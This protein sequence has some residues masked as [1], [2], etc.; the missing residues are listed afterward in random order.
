MPVRVD[1][2]T[3][4]NLLG[5]VLVALAGPLA[6]LALVA[7]VYREPPMPFVIPAVGSLAAGV[8]L[9]RLERSD[10]GPREAFLLVALAWLSVAVVGAIPFVI[11]GV[12]TLADP[13]NALF[14]SMSGITTTGATVVGSFEVHARSILLWRSVLQ[15][16]GGLGILVLA[17]GVLSGLSV[18][19]AQ[20]METETQNQNV[21]KLTPR[22]ART[23][24]ILGSIYAGLTALLV[25][26]LLG[27]RAVGLAP[28]MNLYNAVAHA[29][30]T[31]STAGFSPEA[32]SLGAFSPAVQWVVI[33]FMLV[34][35]TNFVLIYFLL[36]GDTS[37]LRESEE[38]RF[39]LGVVVLAAVIVT[40]VLALDGQFATTEE[41][42]RHALFNVVSII[43]TT[44]YATVDF[45]AWSTG[46]RHVLFLGMFMGGMAGSTTCS[47]QDGSVVGRHQDVPAR[48]VHRDPPFRGGPGAALGPGRR[49]GDD[50]GLLRLHPREHRDLRGVDGVRGGRRRTGGRRDRRIR[51]DG[52]GGLDL[53]QHRPGVRIRGSLRELRGVPGLD[54]TGD[55][56]H[57]VDRP[58]R[59]RA[60]P[61]PLHPF[62]LAVVVGNGGLIRRTDGDR[63]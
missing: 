1:V 19:G 40:G 62:L 12:G 49:R 22:I 31:V 53:P 32:T 39:Y 11:A 5:R 25:V 43:T 10:P 7:L 36:R 24:R 33:L 54:Q 45:D 63:P 8:G 58:D 60:R 50:S 48:P 51:G 61:G 28:N 30:T 23:A 56:G 4:A 18:S 3:S 17:V 38:F 41:T 13:V 16:L 44:G 35:A 14:E 20:L 26:V 34:G 2:R 59:D 46:A 52:C 29:L 27:L 21:T 47:N 42:V 15:W 57:D 9:S 37:R 6:A 55:D